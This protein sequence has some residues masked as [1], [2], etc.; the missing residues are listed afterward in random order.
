MLYAGWSSLIA[1][2]SPTMQNA[3]SCLYIYLVFHRVSQSARHWYAYFTPTTRTRQDCL[4]LSCQC[5]RR[6]LNWRQ[7]K[8]IGDRTFRKWTYLIFCSFVLSRNAGLDKTVQSQI[9]RTTENCLD[10]SPI[11]LTPP[12]QTRQDSLVLS[13]SAVCELGNRITLAAHCV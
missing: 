10:L 1:R 2:R 5:R 7:V 12:T 3:A 9:L 13:V 11:Q 6:E 8:T 4:V